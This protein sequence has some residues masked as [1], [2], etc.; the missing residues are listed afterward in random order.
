MD[1]HVLHFPSLAVKI[2]I[3]FSQCFSRNEVTRNRRTM[4]ENPV[5]QSFGAFFEGWLSRM[6]DLLERLL[7]VSVSLSLPQSA[8]KVEEQRKKVIEQVLS[9]HEQYFHEKSRVADVDVF[10]LL[11]PTWLSFYERALLWIADYKPSLLLR[12][13][14]S[15][16]EGLTAEQDR[17]LEQVKAYTRRKERELT[18][19]ME[20]VQESVAGPSVLEL[21]RRIGRTLDGEISVLNSSIEAL[22][23]AMAGIL[24]KADQLRVSTV[25]KVMDIFSLAQTISAGHKEFGGAEGLTTS[26]GMGGLHLIRMNPNLR[27]FRLSFKKK[28]KN[29]GY[30]RLSS[31]VTLKEHR[32]VLVRG[33]QW[34]V[35]EI[36]LGCWQLQRKEGEESMT[37]DP[38]WLDK[39]G[40]YK[41]YLIYF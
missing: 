36:G 1:S 25:T 6:R 19:A 38:L 7:S 32:I 31:V 17:R 39:N 14:D 26:E 2:S 35:R 22:E 12:L 3:N 30:T 34:S 4:V 11:F 10:L 18:V 15:A 21:A 40:Q 24:E 41:K 20:N 27:P 5:E 8:C 33:G 23:R 13:V 9:H 37:T 16:V 29:D 28:K